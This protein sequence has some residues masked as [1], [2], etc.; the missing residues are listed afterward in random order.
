MLFFSPATSSRAAERQTDQAGSAFSIRWENDTFG[1]TDANYTNGI[2]LALTQKGEGLG[3]GVWKLF[4]DPEGERFA[5]YDLGQLQ[6]TPNDIGRQIPDPTDR[7]YAGFLYLG[8]TTYLKQDESLHGLKLLAGVV[9]PASG[10]ELIQKLTHRLFGYNMPKGWNFQL[11]NEPV[12][13]LLYEYRRKFALTSRETAVG[14]EMIPAG[15]AMLGNYMIQVQAETQFRL[16]YHLPDDFGASVLRGIGY[17]PF[18]GDD[19]KR[20]AWGVYAFAGGSGSLVARNL[21]LDGN[22]FANS[23]SVDKRP[24]LPAAEFGATFWTR[25]FQ[26]SFSYVML[27]KEFYGQRVREDYGSILVSYFFR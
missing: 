20:H 22:T 21:T 4:N 11:K 26:A 13:N 3:G 24:F 14:I 5:T 17:L 16:G 6:F 19:G 1:G 15:G 18:P 7:P 25:Q 23:P 8:I 27:G 2:A 10:S 12:V 9:G